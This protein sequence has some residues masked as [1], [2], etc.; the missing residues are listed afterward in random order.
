MRVQKNHKLTE[1]IVKGSVVT[2]EVRD[3]CDN[4]KQKGTGKFG[5]EELLE[6]EGS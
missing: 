2:G 3:K 4:G 6:L 1:I 5:R